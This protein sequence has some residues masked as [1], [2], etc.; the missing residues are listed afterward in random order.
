MS[1]SPAG[2]PSMVSRKTTTSSGGNKVTLSDAMEW[3][4]Q[5]PLQQ[6]T[7]TLYIPTS[8][9]GAIIGRRGSNIA[10]IQRQAQNLSSATN[11]SNVRVSI[12][13]HKHQH[14]QQQESATLSNEEKS[15]AMNE[16]AAGSAPSSEP[17]ASGGSSSSSSTVVPFTYTELDWSDPDWTPVVVKADVAAA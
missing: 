2:S 8:S 10:N 4:L 6:V 1:A 14:Q 11:S 15:S 7:M 16:D 12:V 13:G 17:G 5:L 9:V 3:T